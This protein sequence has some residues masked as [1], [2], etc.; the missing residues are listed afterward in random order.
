MSLNFPADSLC[1]SY[2]TLERTVTPVIF[3][4]L[5]SVYCMIAQKLS[6]VHFNHREYH[7]LIH[8]LT[9]G[10]RPRPEM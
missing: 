9:L 2:F 7:Y 5:P 4:Q 3:W 6:F 10:T 1:V 8:H